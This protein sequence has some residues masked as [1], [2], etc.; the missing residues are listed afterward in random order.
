MLCSTVALEIV[1]RSSRDF[2]VRTSRDHEC[3]ATTVA[4]NHGAEHVVEGFVAESRDWGAS[5]IIM[6]RND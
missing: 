5:S 3:I 2:A 6:G 4:L 1:K